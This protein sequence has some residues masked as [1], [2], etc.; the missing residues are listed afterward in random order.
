MG[1]D[2]FNLFD[3]NFT[4]SLLSE[5]PG[6]LNLHGIEPD[7]LHCLDVILYDRNRQRRDPVHL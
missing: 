4:L 2:A 3:I 7:L 5:S 6:S 1:Y